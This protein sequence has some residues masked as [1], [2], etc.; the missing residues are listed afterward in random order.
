MGKITINPCVSIEQKYLLHL[1]QQI[2]FLHYK[3]HGPNWRDKQN[4]FHEKCLSSERREKLISLFLSVQSAARVLL[5]SQLNSWMKIWLQPS[6]GLE[7]LVSLLCLV[8]PKRSPLTFTPQLLNQKRQHALTECNNNN[9]LKSVR[10]ILIMITTFIII[11][12]F[13]LIV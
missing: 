9:I 4:P 12:I 6:K 8:F 5:F 13:I 7:S 3:T 2:Q 10:I 11:S 1:L